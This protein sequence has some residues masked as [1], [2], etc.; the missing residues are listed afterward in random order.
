[1]CQWTLA[2]IL[3]ISNVSIDVGNLCAIVACQFVVIA[4]DAVCFMT[5]PGRSERHVRE[6]GRRLG[7]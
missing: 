5:L 1:M 7:I 3:L 6:T 4:T 2:H